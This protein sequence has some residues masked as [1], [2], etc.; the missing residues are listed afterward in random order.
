MQFD[1]TQS[2]AFLALLDPTTTEF[3]FQT[4]DDDKSNGRIKRS[5]LADVLS[6][7]LDQHAGELK[8]LSEQ[9]AGIFVSV[10]A[11]DGRGRRLA[12]ITRLRAIFQ[13]ADD[14]TAP[15]PPLEPH[16]VVGSSPGKFHRYWLIDAATE[17]SYTDW[18]AVMRRMIADWGSDPDA[19]DVSRVLRLPGFPHQKDPNN[20]HMVRLVAKS[21]RV[22]YRWDEI[23]AVIPPLPLPPSPP[24]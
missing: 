23:T 8:R 22:P 7:N 2:A 13:E 4:F 17:P 9:G 19:K 18:T 15:V 10:N 21:N 14:L 20:P 5:E 16:I 6:G 1:L 11:T 3:C 12:N 24:P